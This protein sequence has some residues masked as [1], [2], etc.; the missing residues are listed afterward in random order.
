M[1]AIAWLALMSK[2]NDVFGGPDVF[3]SFPALTP[4]S[5]TPANLNVS[6]ALSDP[7]VGHTL[8]DLSLNVNS[9]PTGTLFQAATDNLLW[10]AYNK[11]LND[12]VL[13]TDQMSNDE[14]A[15]YD[16]AT[17]LLTAKDSNG[18]LVDSPM[19]VSYKQYRDGWF[20]ANQNYLNA[21][22]TA[23][24]SSDSTTQDQWNNVDEPR[25]RALI[26]QAT[27][28]WQNK[29]YKSQ[30]E[31]AQAVKAQLESRSPSSAWNSWRSALITDIDL[32]TDPVSNMQYAPTLFSPTDLF[33]GDWPTFLLST[34]EIK[35]LASTAP[36]ELRNVFSS[37]NGTSSVTCL[38]FQFRSA[39]LV[40]SWL[41]T[42]VFKARFWKFADGTVLSDG[43]APPQ[44]SWPA[45]ISGVVFA[46]NIVV[47]MQNAPQPQSFPG[48]AVSKTMLSPAALPTVAWGH[49][50]QPPGPASPTI[51]ADTR[52]FIKPISPTVT[53]V[54]S[55]P[56]VGVIANRPMIATALAPAPRISTVSPFTRL[57]ATT[58]RLPPEPLHG[59]VPS[60]PSPPAPSSAPQTTTANNSISV[61][62][63]ICRGLPQTPNPDSS[64]NWAP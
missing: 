10:D 41:N 25:L 23:E 34:D 8:A 2:A 1:D 54:T 38:S 56:A 21:K 13:A 27:S 61:L 19:V 31:N 18:L 44:G 60:A 11:W 36:N 40:R 5:Y 15:E 17:A 47:T 24:A 51:R 33:T 43:A 42:D 45:Y 53:P 20:T 39:A 58:Y 26:D 35:Q 29:G 37:G 3:L 50:T 52:Q 59:T 14:K 57:M 12:M 49:V 55:K 16:Q 22:S 46:R 6:A 63:F 64:L 30:V 62:A 7:Q 4:I 48:L 32:P 28:D 9:L